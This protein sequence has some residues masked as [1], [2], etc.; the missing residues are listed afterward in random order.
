[1]QHSFL[2]NSIVIIGAALLIWV[3]YVT[4][5]QKNTS[6]NSNTG[7]ASENVLTGDSPQAQSGR[8]IL[9]LLLNL[10]SLKLDASIFSDPSFQSLA[11][12][13]QNIPARPHGRGN[14]FAPI[15]TGNV[16]KIAF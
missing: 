7:L 3:G 6:P 5:F 1:M 12:F 10:K 14:P 16:S 13:G 8:E 11:D 4:F 2:K 9:A 15:G